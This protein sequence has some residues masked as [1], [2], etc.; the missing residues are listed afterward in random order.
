MSNET[1]T[2]TPDNEAAIAA[3]QKVAAENAEKATAA[4]AKA[5][6]ENE[7]KAAAKGKLPRHTGK[8]IVVKTVHP[9]KLYCPTQDVTIRP[10]SSQEVVDDRW[11]RSQLNNGVL[12][13][14]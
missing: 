3:Q 2:K 4:A 8:K 12:E 10:D 9:F 14:V 13:K 7:A 6:E 11:V 5:K 1:E